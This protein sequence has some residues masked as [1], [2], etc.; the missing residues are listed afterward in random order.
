M[1]DLADIFSDAQ[2]TAP[3]N[4]TV[5]RVVTSSWLSERGVHTRK[6]LIFLKRKC[7]GFNLIEEDCKMVGADEALAT[8]RNLNKVKDGVY[9]LVIVN[10]RRDWE[11]GHIEEWEFD[12]VP[13]YG[14]EK[15]T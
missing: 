7:A 5:V 11:T 2:E 3:P 15:E 4:R 9:E 13:F 10:E 6:D 8:V 1:K 14:K 12:L